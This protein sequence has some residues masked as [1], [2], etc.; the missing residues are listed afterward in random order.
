MQNQLRQLT[1]RLNKRL[2]AAQDCV[3]LDMGLEYV[4][5]EVQ[6]P[7][8]ERLELERW[9]AANNVPRARLAL[10]RTDR[11]R[12]LSLNDVVRDR[13]VNAKGFER[14]KSDWW[15]PEVMH[16]AI[17]LRGVGLK[18]AGINTQRPFTVENLLLAADEWSEQALNSSAVIAR[19]MLRTSESPALRG[20][21]TT[22]FARP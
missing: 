1:L 9:A 15:R 18:W 8:R 20:F 2:V 7:A 19:C 22:R 14:Y 11:G 16:L 5:I 4:G 13:S 12:P 21:Q 17:A 10:T 6:I 3:Y